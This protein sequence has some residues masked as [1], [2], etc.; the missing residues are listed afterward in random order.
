[1]SLLRAEQ[2]SCSFGSLKAVSGVSLS[3]AAGELRALIGANGAGK[4]TFFNLISGFLAP[5]SGAIIFDGIDITG[6]PAH[7]RVG[8]GIARTFQ[9][10]EVFPDLSVRENLRIPVEVASGMARRPWLSRGKAEAVMERVDQLLALGGLADRSERLAGEL[11]HGDQRAIEILM[12][13]ALKPRLLLLDEPT[14]GMGDQETFDITELIR[15]LH[16]EHALSI[17]LV[18]HDMRVVFHL[19]DRIMVMAEGTVLADGTP[20]QIAADERVQSAYLG[21]GDA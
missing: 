18:E 2:V 13:L 1:V 20:E 19:A 16:R 11:A 8:M 10:T 21:Q 7:R 3:I 17:L 9:I 15:R 14:A 5:T 4:T 12:A 6:V